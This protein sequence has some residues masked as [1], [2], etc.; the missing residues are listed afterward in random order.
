MQSQSAAIEKAAAVN[1][2]SVDAMGAM[3]AMENEQC[4]VA[5]KMTFTRRELTL[6]IPKSY[7]DTCVKVMSPYRAGETAPSRSFRRTHPDAI[8]RIAI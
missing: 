7:K 8:H 4:D 2:D 6:E 5:T 3:G 1:A